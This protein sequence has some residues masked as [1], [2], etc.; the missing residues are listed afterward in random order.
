VNIS[1]LDLYNFDVA[2][3]IFDVADVEFRY[4]RHMLGVVSMREEEGP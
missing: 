3:I 4:C 1:K 2:N